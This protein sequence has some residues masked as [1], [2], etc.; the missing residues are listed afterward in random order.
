MEDDDC[1]TC[2]KRVEDMYWSHFKY[3]QFF[4]ILSGEY[5]QQLVSSN[6]EY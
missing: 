4:Q 5:R 2:K 3:V 6:H 1:R